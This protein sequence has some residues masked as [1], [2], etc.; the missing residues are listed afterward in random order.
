L[1]LSPP[2]CRRCGFPSEV[3][4]PRCRQCPSGAIDVARA[5]FLFEGPA[6]SAVHALKF[7]GWRDVAAALAGAMVELVPGPADAVAWVPLSRRRL[8]ERGFDQA[9]VLAEAVGEAISLPALH[10]VRRTEDTAPQAQRIGPERREAMEGAFRAAGRAPPRVLLVDDV[11]TTGA[12]AA[13]CSHAFRG[14]GAR[15]VFVITA[16][17]A[18]RAALPGRYT[19]AGLTPGSVVARGV[20]PR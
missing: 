14:A 15:E 16:A 18:G 19:R 3:E 5:P 6:R 20:F 1:A 17:R 8:A 2:W 13:A 9:R 4:A 11:L 12:T 10:L 7:R